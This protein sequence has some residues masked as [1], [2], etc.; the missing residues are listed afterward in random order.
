MGILL[1]HWSELK[2]KWSACLAGWDLE[3]EKE[4]QE[5]ETFWV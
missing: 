2:A 3:V 1:N 5:A 4:S